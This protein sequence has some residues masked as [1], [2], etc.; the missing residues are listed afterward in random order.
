MQVTV[1][2]D[3]VENGET[4]KKQEK[5]EWRDRAEQPYSDRGS[6]RQRRSQC[7]GR[8][9]IVIVSLAGIGTRTS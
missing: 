1:G 3:D 7:M 4:G 2:E 5:E 9:E 8:K 6:R